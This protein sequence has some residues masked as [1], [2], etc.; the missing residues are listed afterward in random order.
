MIKNNPVPRNAPIA[1]LSPSS[2]LAAEAFRM[3]QNSSTLS[4]SSGSYG[5]HGSRKP[6][7][8][9][10]LDLATFAGHRFLS[11]GSSRCTTFQFPRT[12]GADQSHFVVHFD[13]RTGC[14]ELTDTS[15]SGIL[16]SHTNDPP[17]EPSTFTLL[18][19]ATVAIDKTVFIR[20]RNH[21]GLCFRL[22]VAVSSIVFAAYVGTIDRGA[23]HQGLRDRAVTRRPTLAVRRAE[24]SIRKP[25]RAHAHRLQSQI[26]CCSTSASQLT[27]S[28]RRSSLMATQAGS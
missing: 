10:M 20:L 8:S 14:L 5:S 9:A 26:T 27:I 15:K 28:R 19:H 16:V 1:F 25:T 6:S 4:V 22:D 2:T 3:R 21:E 12:W 7:V 13:M 17:N 18:H 23:I 11:F 24:R